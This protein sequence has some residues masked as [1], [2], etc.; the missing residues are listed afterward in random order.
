[1]RFLEVI[2][3]WINEH[4]SNEEAIYLVVLLVAAFVVL[5]FFGA[6]IA[7][8]L[9]GL[10]FAYLLSAV[11]DRLVDWH[12]PRLAAVWIVFALFVGGAIALVIGIAPLI[13]RQLTE[14]VNAMPGVIDRLRVL[15]GDL[16][17][18]FPGTF[19]PTA[20]EGWLAALNAEVT[21]IGK[22]ALQG[23]VAQVPN[24]FGIIIYLI[25]LP[26]SFFFF[27][28]DGKS[29]VARVL[30][31]LPQHRTLLDS[32]GREMN[33]QIANYIRGKAIEILI[34]GTVTYL[35]FLFLGLNYAALL[36]FV[37]GISVLVPFVG[38]AV[39]TVPV[40]A[41]GFLQYGWSWD[42]AYVMAAYGVIQALDGNVLVPILFSETND[43]HPITIIVA[44][45]AFGGLWGFWGILFAI[46]LATLVKAIFN[47]WPRTNVAQ[48]PET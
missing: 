5:F 26:I 6:Y 25:L 34:V 30:A 11:V 40:A 29:M 20:I 22:A 36:G 39:V 4:F 10:I 24:V 23:L 47:A 2:G 42:F 9:A 7:P 21:E 16:S 13:W 1:M 8:V 31:M 38:A 14:S 41:V 27:L 48:A 15:L 17:T 12:V 35:A 44:V 37:V 33:V 45:L 18:E 43:L 3:G 46:P 28:K 32:V 19:S